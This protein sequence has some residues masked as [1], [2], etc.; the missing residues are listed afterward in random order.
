MEL[1]SAVQFMLWICA[2]AASA[3]GRIRDAAAAG[4]MTSTGSAA[5]A[6]L[7]PGG[8]RCRCAR[9]HAGALRPPEN[10]RAG[11]CGR[12]ARRAARAA[13]IFGLFGFGSFQGSDARVLWLIMCVRRPQMAA[14]E[15]RSRADW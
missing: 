6:G 4:S 1:W 9:I 13:S 10:C 14:A 15:A 12:M 2:T 11:W 5:A 8:R 3:A 7:R